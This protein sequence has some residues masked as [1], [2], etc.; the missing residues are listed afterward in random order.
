MH[1]LVQPVSGRETQVDSGGP[2]LNQYRDRKLPDIPQA[3]KLNA[4]NSFHPPQPAG[5]SV[6]RGQILN[7]YSPSQQHTSNRAMDLTHPHSHSDFAVR[8][9]N[10]SLQD[11]RKPDP[12]PPAASSTMSS[13]FSPS[14]ST[15]LSNPNTGAGV[16]PGLRQRDLS[17]HRKLQSDDLSAGFAYSL[18]SGASYYSPL[19]L[20]AS[21]GISSSGSRNSSNGSV[22]RDHGGHLDLKR[23]LSRPALH[24]ASGS[25]AVSLPSDSEVSGSSYIHSHLGADTVTRLAM[26]NISGTSS[27]EEQNLQVGPSGSRSSSG[28]RSGSRD[29]SPAA[30]DAERER[31]LSPRPSRNVLRRKPSAR[32]NPT[33]APPPSRDG[34][35]RS[36]GTLPHSTSGKQ[37]LRSADSAHGAPYRSASA[38]RQ[39]A[40]ATSAST[41]QKEP[42]IPV[43]LTPAG[44]VA[45]AYKQQEQRREELAETSSYEDLIRRQGVSVHG[46]SS[47]T[48]QPPEDLDELK[49]ESNGP[50]YTVFGGISE[51][52]PA[53]ADSQGDTW[54][55]NPYMS[56]EEHR[57]KTHPIPGMRKSLSRKVSGRLKKVADIVKRDRDISPSRVI[58]EDQARGRDADA[59][60]PYDGQPQKRRSDS[61]PKSPRTPVRMSMDDYVD[62]SGQSKHSRRSIPTAKNGAPETA[63]EEGRRSEGVGSW[64]AKS[65]KGKDR[66]F[67]EDSSPGGKWWKLVKRLSTGGLRDKYR[68]RDS[69]PPPV[70]ALP[71][72]F[73]KLALPRMTFELPLKSTPGQDGGDDGVLLSR[74]M[75][76]RASLSGVQT[77]PSPSHRHK[78]SPPS[79]P[80]TGNK[81][82]SA[83]AGRPSTTTR[84]SSPGSSD[85]ASSGFFHRA[86]STRS[87]TSSY[88]EELPPMPKP[89]DSPYG[90]HIV[91]PSELNRLNAEQDRAKADVSHKL[92]QPNRSRSAPV[93]DVRIASSVDDSRPS[94]P[95]PPRRRPPSATLQEMSPSPIIPSFPLSSLS[96]FGTLG[97]SNPPPRPKRSDQR[98]PARIDVMTLSR[99]MQAA[100]VPATP[101]PHPSVSVDLNFSNRSSVNRSSYA[102][103]A[104]QVPPSPASSAS[105]SS[106]TRSPLT[107]R[108]MESPRH[109]WTEQEKTSKW[110]DLLQR[111]D[112]AGGTLR[113]GESGLLSE[114]MNTALSEYSESDHD[115]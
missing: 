91:P 53:T 44:R 66:D 61:I 107:F 97:P 40:S 5:S 110:E 8:D 95:L 58:H 70:P 51:H 14:S 55:F 105:P 11:R 92:R 37:R 83:I 62:V 88:G 50:Y 31:A 43:G 80:S 104:K 114:E 54:I 65:G 23:L 34:Q 6:T 28:H 3:D 90:Q 29:V 32:S 85:I 89:Y 81:S 100:N 67:N 25:S 111:S 7:P 75:Q 4:T 18:S 73:H 46:S 30:Q 48:D 102:S 38:P 2:S 49:E 101:R 19:T 52:R 27:R 45:H 9:S 64:A 77:T 94:L 108:E 71:Q 109:A 1:T 36:A 106:A 21:L 10:T 41:R 60:R 22:D 15:S 24:K 17:P 115:S 84:S 33:V 76:S 12:M 93:N 16:R 47:R 20:P 57:S 112:R 42:P 96:E 69:S 63:A 59:W 99:S 68:Q 87:S 78:A 39:A 35:P 82:S 72:D 26:Y 103:T 13:M 86:H 79:R 113:L 56:M 74:F 98:K